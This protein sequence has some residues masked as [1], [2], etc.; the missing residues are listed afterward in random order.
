MFA[1]SDKV[2]CVDDSP[3]K[4]ENRYTGK[5]VPLVRDQIYVVD[6][7][8]FEVRSSTSIVTLV[9]INMGLTSFG[10][11]FGFCATRFR[12]LAD[13]KAENTLRAAIDLGIPT[14]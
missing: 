7:V 10:E 14:P 3:G 9:G 5:P 12:K 4:G 8:S 2:V 1:I 11:P 6:S 13:I